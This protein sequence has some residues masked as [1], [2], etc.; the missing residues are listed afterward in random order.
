MPVPGDKKGS[1]LHDDTTSRHS[2]LYMRSA[3]DVGSDEGGGG[4]AVYHVNESVQAVALGS[5]A[6][7][8]V[9]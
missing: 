5:V 1:E 6:L 2:R 3:R 4:A 9:G 8:S 7:G